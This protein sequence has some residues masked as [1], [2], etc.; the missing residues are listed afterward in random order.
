[1]DIFEPAGDVAEK[2]PLMILCFGGGFVQGSR[3]YWS[4]RLLAQGLAR[5][6]FVVASIDYR[7]GMDLF[8]KDIGARS[9]YRAV[10][11]SRSAVR[12]FRA[13]ASTYD[14]D[15]DKIFIGGHSSGAFVAMHNIYL[16]K[17]SERPDSTFAGFQGNN[18]FPDL[19]CLDCVGDNLGF[20]GQATASFNLAG[21]LGDL[22]FVENSNEPPLLQFHSSDDGT[23]PYDTGE[24]FSDISGFIIGSDLPIVF[25][26]LPTAQRFTDL[27]VL[28]DFRSYT[29]RGHGV[30]ENGMVALHSDILPTIGAWFFDQFLEPAPADISG[31]K[32]LCTSSLEQSYSVP[33]N[34]FTY[35]DWQITGGA[36]VSMST[37]SNNV[38]V[39]WDETAP[40]HELSIKPYEING[41]GAESTLFDV[42]VVSQATNSWNLTSGG[43]WG[44]SSNWNLGRV[45]LTCED[46]VISTTNAG[47]EVQMEGNVD[48]QVRSLELN[49]GV[50]LNIPGTSSLEVGQN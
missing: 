50:I 15:S 42:I 9:V 18:A 32:A 17:E 24:P 2:R 21:A 12:F 11:D 41:A 35:F 34:D 10:Q 26:S 8:D 5:R 40:V 39:L 23:V 48:Y 22:A 44:N 16:D 43:Q 3:D 36:F 30:H 19:G 20:N 49:D 33:G 37:S 7:L 38:D 47:F 6:G 28:N 4:I 25:G 45:P 1:M 13:N 46:V 29:D 31:V 27:T 14:I